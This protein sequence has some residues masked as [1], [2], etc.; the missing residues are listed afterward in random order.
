MKIEYDPI[1]DAMYVHLTDGEVD[2]TEEI[3]PGILLDYDTSGN[4]LGIEV[5]YMS[6]RSESPLKQ[7]A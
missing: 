1:A 7:A 2:R 4:V 3:K 5:L 6:K